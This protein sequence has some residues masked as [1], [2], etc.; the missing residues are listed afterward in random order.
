[1]NFFW[2]LI[3][4]F[5][6]PVAIS[7]LIEVFRRA[8]VAPDKLNW[9][10]TI[11]ICYVEVDGVKLRYIKTG[12]GPALVLL[13]TLRTQLDIFQKVIP[14][15]SRE[16]TV[17][18]LDFPGHGFSDIPRTEYKPE[19]FYRAVTGFLE[20]LDIKD[21]VVAGIS[22]G[23]TVALVLAAR[24]NPRIKRAIA[25]NPYDY[26]AGHG[27]ERSSAV[28]RVVLGLSHIPVIGPTVM[29]MRNPLV[30]RKIMEGGVADPASLPKSLLDEMYAV[31]CRPGHY[32]AFI[33][34]IRNSSSE[35]DRARDEYGTIG[36]PVFLIY[37][38]QDWSM[39]AER[40]DNLKT[41]PGAQ[42]EI[43]VNGGHFL[44]LDRPEEVVRLIL[45]FGKDQESSSWG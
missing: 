38:D 1:M 2:I 42:M 44:S 24:K 45:R 40:Q 32:Q 3:A 10:P 26:G 5:L 31:G 23:G 25:I 21:A 6:A 20:E 29:R 41:I 16:F 22:I 7:Y 43:V 34:L 8:P 30:E 19:V 27:V 28:A 37:G 9:D 13:H 36:I 39:L 4:L 33:S 11:P 12:E 14:A 15:L 17:Y 35:W 18:A